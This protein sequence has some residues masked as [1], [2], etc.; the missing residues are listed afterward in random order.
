M[1]R[2]PAA[3][4]ARANAR[5]ESMEM[6]AD[7][8]GSDILIGARG[9]RRVHDRER[10]AQGGVTRTRARRQKSASWSLTPG[11]SP[12]TS[13]ERSRRPAARRRR[14]RRASPSSSRPRRARV[15]KASPTRSLS[16]ELR[17]AATALLTRITSLEAADARSLA[18]RRRRRR[19]LRRSCRPD[20]RRCWWRWRPRGMRLR[21]VWSRRRRGRGRSRRG[22]P[23]WNWRP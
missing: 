1:F 2:R 17:E 20:L 5:G 10:G 14:R 18:N 19:L 11:S 23:S 16:P 4:V 9:C 3:R 12:P 13:R 7:S 8:A 21:R 6:P 15:M 22:Q